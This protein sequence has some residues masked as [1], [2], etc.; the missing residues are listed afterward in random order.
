[1]SLYLALCITEDIVR[2]QFSVSQGSEPGI[3]DRAQ[4]EYRGLGCLFTLAGENISKS[5]PVASPWNMFC[6]AYNNNES[7]LLEQSWH[8]NAREY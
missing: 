8:G 2:C 1:M 6:T 5:N 4:L 7:H 3:W